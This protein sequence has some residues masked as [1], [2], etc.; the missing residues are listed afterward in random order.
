MLRISRSNSPNVCREKAGESVQNNNLALAGDN[1]EDTPA[2]PS[3]SRFAGFAAL[4]DAMDGG[5]AEEEEDFGG[6][7]VRWRHPS[8]LFFQLTLPQ[9]AIKSSQANKGKKEKKKAK[10]APV[11][12][13]LDLPDDDDAKPVSKAPVEVTAD[14][15]ADEEW[16]PVKEKGGKKKKGK[17]KNAATEET[18]ED[19]SGMFM[20]APY[21]SVRN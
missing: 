9:S 19:E 1:D 12:D 8:S 5:G 3:K 6:L 16:G 7:M 2:A 17:G 13:D 10:K 18:A 20:P 11:E 4:D 14:D 21:K 15:L